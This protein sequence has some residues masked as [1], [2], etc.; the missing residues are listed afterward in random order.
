MTRKR[1]QKKQEPEFLKPHSLR[2]VFGTI[3]F[4]GLRAAPNRT[5]QRPR[6]SQNGNRTHCPEQPRWSE[7]PGGCG[8]T[9]A[10][11]HC[12]GAYSSQRNKLPVPMRGSSIHT[13]WAA[14]EDFLSS[15]LRTLQRDSSGALSLWPA[16]GVGE[17]QDPAGPPAAP[18]PAPQG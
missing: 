10:F 1:V 5:Q 16:C 12:S 4:T 2:T 13:G 6:Q 3:L 9:A 11:S 8:S 14:W 15:S 17:G 18:S 7:L